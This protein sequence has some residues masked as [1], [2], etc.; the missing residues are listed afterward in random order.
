VYVGEVIAIIEKDADPN[1]DK[2]SRN[3]EDREIKK[4][5]NDLCSGRVK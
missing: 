5:R 3:K 4:R 1:K 2:H